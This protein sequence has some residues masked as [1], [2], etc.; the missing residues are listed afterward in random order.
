MDTLIQFFNKY[1]NAA[2]ALSGGADSA[3]VLMLAAEHMG[4]E[5]VTAVTCV[6]SHYFKSELQQA[7]RIAG[8]LGV[9]HIKITAEMPAE[10]YKGDGLRC[11]HCKKTVMSGLCQMDFGV[12]FDGTNA[13][14]DPAE[15][16]GSR[17]IDELGIV[18]P[19]KEMGLGKDFAVKKVS[20]LGLK[21]LNE[22]C[23]ATRMENITEE[24]MKQVEEFEEKLRYQFIGIRY[25]IDRS[26]VEFK[27]PLKIS[28]K[29]FMLINEVKRPFCGAS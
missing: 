29:D 11:Y 14:D 13:D 21:F 17:A 7:E 4:P 27:T 16:P 20:E 1:K 26:F 19:L 5:N 28:D 6:N 24:K 25:R 18:S 3:C 12:I 9:K 15:R 8:K 2:V 10:F 22:S 23:L